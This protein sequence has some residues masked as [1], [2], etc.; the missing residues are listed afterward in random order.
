MLQEYKTDVSREL[1]DLREATVLE[2]STY[3]PKHTTYSLPSINNPLSNSSIGIKTRS[4]VASAEGGICPTT[5]TSLS[6]V[7]YDL[8]LP[9]MTVDPNTDRPP[10]IVQKQCLVGYQ[11]FDITLMNQQ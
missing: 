8:A 3:L 7:Q 4:T 9:P 11:D 5:N 6:T 2:T 1:V 10:I